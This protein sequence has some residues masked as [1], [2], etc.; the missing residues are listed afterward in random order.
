MSGEVLDLIERLIDRFEASEAR[1]AVLV[2]YERYLLGGAGAAAARRARA[3]G[4]E[5]VHR[6]L[7]RGDAARVPLR[8][9][10]RRRHQRARH[11]RRLRAGAAVRLAR[12]G[13]RARGAHR[14]QRDAARHR[15]A[16]VGAGAAQAGGAAGVAGADRLRGRLF[17]PAEA[18][19]LGLVHELSPGGELEARATARARALATVPST[20]VAQVKLGLRRRGA[21]D[22]RAPRRRGDRALARH[23]VLAGGARAPA[24]GGGQ[25]AS[26][27]AMDVARI[28][29]RAPTLVF[30]H[31]GLG[32]R[33]AWRDFP[34]A[35]AR[36]TGR[37][38]IV[39][40]RAGYGRS[41]LRPRAVAG[42][43]SCTTRRAR[44]RRC[45]PT[46]ATTPSSSD[47]PTARRSRCSTR[48]T[49]PRARA[50]PRGAARVR[51]GQDGGVDRGVA[52]ACRG[53]ASTRLGRHHDDARATFDALERAC[54]SIR[55][56]ARW[57]IEACLPRVRAPTLVIQGEDDEY[58]T[59]AQVDAV[60]PPARRPVRDAAVARVRP[61]AAPRSAGAHARR[62][63]R[64]HRRVRADSS[65]DP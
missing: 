43:A 24:G 46:R 37:A 44:C 34:G 55:R 58:G 29:G 32:S 16:V 11:R 14:A 28:D 21:R 63:G 12:D 25:A 49:Q 6:A 3:A 39:C 33:S 60:A 50:R 9:A 15:A 36:A 5:A 48:P 23:L 47:T 13:R 4:D 8:A 35:L 20:A 26:L 53:A 38:A 17:A 54:G 52:R 56:F 19:A 45:S 22:D 1:A 42:R 62:D 31:E 57:N 59:V 40:S 18:L 65:R 64:L 30:L 7:R 61:R 27:M 51:R 10:D 2:G 41:P